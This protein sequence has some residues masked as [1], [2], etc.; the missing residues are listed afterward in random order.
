MKKFIITEQERKHILSLYNLVEDFKTQKKRFI[1]QGYDESIV[2]TYL[3]DFRQIKDKRFKEAS[4]SDIQGLSVPK[5]NDRF[6]IDSYKTFNELESLVDYVS[7]Q[8]NVGNANFSDIKVDGKPIYEDDKVEIYYAPNKQSCVE[9]KGNR[10]YSWCISRED[11][12]NMF[13]RYRF[14][15]L[16]PTFYFVKRKLAMQREFEKWEGKEFNGKFFDKWHFFVI[17]VTSNRGE[18]KSIYKYIITSAENDGEEKVDWNQII[19][20]APELKGLEKYFESIP[21]SKEEKEKYE[22]FKQGISDEEFSKLS[23]TDKIFYLDV[24]V[25]EYKE[26]SFSKFKSLPEDLKNKY[27]NLGIPLSDEQYLLIKDE[28]KLLKRYAEV[29]EKKADSVLKMGRGFMTQK[30]YSLI[31]KTQIDSL[32]E[33]KRNEVYKKLK[34]DIENYLFT[35]FPRTASISMRAIKE[36]VKDKKRGNWEVAGLAIPS[37]FFLRKLIDKD[38]FIK[39]KKLF[40][41]FGFNVLGFK[42]KEEFL[43][44]LDYVNIN[45]QSFLSDLND[46]DK[47][48]ATTLLSIVD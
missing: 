14:G 7:G 17:Q 34:T 37:V 6:N 3:N 35:E 16:Q 38:V 24:G 5:G 19:E 25:N 48:L 31:T 13:Q 36:I 15:E 18:I 11:A 39:D 44:F 4:D 22:R 47:D 32:D 26:L 8:K 27:I 42:G 41:D 2:D 46:K 28:R 33:E 9:Y 40:Y 43:K 30:S 29:S 12:S 23:Y 1:N 20:I 45:L 10:P 21:I